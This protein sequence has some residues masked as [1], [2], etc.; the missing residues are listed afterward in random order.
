MSFII[1]E[2][3]WEKMQGLL[4][5]IVQDANTSQVLMLGYMNQAALQAT[6]DTKQVTFF[7]RSKNRLWVK[8]ETSGNY[9]LLS[10]I[11][12][13]CDQDTLLIFAH[14]KGPVCHTGTTSC[15]RD[16]PVSDWA[17][18]QQ[19]E[20]TIASREHASVDNSYTAKL[21]NAGIKKIAQ[22]VGEEGVE[23]A[24]AA[25]AEDD[26]A[27]KGEAADLLFHLLVLLQAR[28]MGVADVINQLR[29]RS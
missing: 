3:A 21:F 15:F 25:V 26:T 6:L 27:F 18:I 9:L 23:V 20:H 8:G 19:L 28:K 1:E 22:K 5:A 17:F 13:D 2:L 14:P 10:H 29:L 16:A 4:P 12:I 7:S 11:C 24:L